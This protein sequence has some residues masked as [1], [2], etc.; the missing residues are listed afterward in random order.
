ML[1]ALV[2]IKKLSIIDFKSFSNEMEK[3]GYKS[4]ENNYII[5]I[6]IQLNSYMALSYKNGQRK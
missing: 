2:I 1:L 4:M 3:H 6:L 5:S